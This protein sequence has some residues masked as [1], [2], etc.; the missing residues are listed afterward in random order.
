MAS[1]RK[2]KAIEEELI[3]THATKLGVHLAD[4]EIKGNIDMFE[5]KANPKIHSLHQEL[6]RGV[7][8][9]N[10]SIISSVYFLLCCEL[11]LT[12]FMLLLLFVF[13]IIID[14]ILMVIILVAMFVY[15]IGYCLINRYPKKFQKSS[16]KFLL[17]LI[18]SICEAVV[19]SFLSIPISTRVFL[20]E[21]SMLII[22][23]FGGCVFAKIKG[24]EYSEKQ[25][26][27]CLVMTTLVLYVIFML[28]FYD[29]LWISLCTFGLV[30]Y[31]WFLVAKI[32]RIVKKLPDVENIDN[33]QNGLYV[34][35]LI[36]KAKIDI[37]V[38]ALVIVCRKC[39]KPNDSEA[40]EN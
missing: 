14:L 40:E 3:E 28:V 6:R 35:L 30:F 20:L 9:H 29:Y 33:F 23:L 16:S 13:S 32:S 31:E 25:G 26:L 18:F 8:Q 37:F 7:L 38:D 39:C 15:L 34:T 12:F 1:K 19:L 11:M 10:L 21:V 4:E 17:C 27:V 5:S 22:S 36:F 24:Q 2:G